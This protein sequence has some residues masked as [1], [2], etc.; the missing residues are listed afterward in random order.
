MYVVAQIRR[1]GRCGD[2]LRTC[3]YP[4]AGEGDGTALVAVMAVTLVQDP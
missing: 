3:D 1:L 2:P 4:E